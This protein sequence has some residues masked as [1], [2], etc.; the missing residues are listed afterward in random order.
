[1]VVASEDSDSDEVVS[2]ASAEV[3]A[4]DEEEFV[5]VA[6]LDEAASVSDE[7]LPHAVKRSGVTMSAAKATFFEERLIDKVLLLINHR[8]APENLKIPGRFTQITLAKQSS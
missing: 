1:M 7:S 2:A 6:A 4:L 5:V 8:H 3:A